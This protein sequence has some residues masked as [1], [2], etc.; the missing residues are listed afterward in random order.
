MHG[1]VFSQ[2]IKYVRETHGLDTLQVILEDSGF[3]NKKF[4]ITES[5]PD[6]QLEK[7]IASTGKHLNVSRDSLLESLGEFI[8]PNLLEIYSPFIE[9][10]WDAMDLLE[11]IES[12]IHRTVRMRDPK[13]DPPKL[14]IERVG[15]DK[16]V[17][18]YFSQRKM[19]HFGIGIIK[20]IGTQYETKLSINKTDFD[21]KQVLE[22]T[23]L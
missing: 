13:A 10:E 6:E 9:K 1:I 23:R 7:M 8:A 19:I 17:I 2:F 3:E 22:V 15:T 11:N 12:T 4:E 18:N 20:A 16:I 14:T 5:H 21:D